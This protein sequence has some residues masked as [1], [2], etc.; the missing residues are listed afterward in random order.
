MSQFVSGISLD[1]LI[2]GPSLCP[3]N[4]TGPKPGFV[5]QS[6]DSQVFVHWPSS[7]IDLPNIDSDTTY[8]PNS[9]VP[10]SN[11]FFE[12][13]EAEEIPKVLS[14]KQKRNQVAKS[15]ACSKD[16]GQGWSLRVWCLHKL[17]LWARN[18]A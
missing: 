14:K 4:L 10:E 8:D 1:S 17:T 9:A 3:Q 12:V 11:S 13:T 18:K 6:L 16:K 7:G 2:T 5:F 15:K